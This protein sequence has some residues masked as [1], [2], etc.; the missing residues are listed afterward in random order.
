MFALRLNEIL[1]WIDNDSAKLDDP[2]A[3]R[4]GFRAH[5]VRL[6][7]DFLAFPHCENFAL[8]PDH[9]DERACDK[10]DPGLKKRRPL[11]AG[12]KRARGASALAV[13]DH[14]EEED[15]DEPKR[16]EGEGEITRPSL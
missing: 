6:T 1:R 15:G 13:V 3:L 16:P 8:M 14:E 9:D 5:I 4:D 11:E 7:R 10:G 12:A 2:S